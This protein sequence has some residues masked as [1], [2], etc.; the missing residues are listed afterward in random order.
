MTC[1]LVIYNIF[2]QGESDTF[3]ERYSFGYLKNTQIK[4]KSKVSKIFTSI[5]R[6]ISFSS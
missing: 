2:N 5:Y 1:N 3:E 4:E 6:K